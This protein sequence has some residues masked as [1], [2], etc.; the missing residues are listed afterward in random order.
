MPR[1]RPLIR[2]EQT[3]AALA[4]VLLL[5]VGAGAVAVT[6]A[7]ES[8]PTA[9]A[10]TIEPLRIERD[11]SHARFPY[12]GAVLLRAADDER[13]LAAAAEADRAAADRAAAERRRAAAAESRRADR[14]SRVR[15]PGGAGGTLGCI[16]SYEGDYGTE[17]GNGYSGAYQFDQ[18][19]WDGA[20]RRA[21]FAEWIGRRPSSA[22]PAVQDAVAAQLLAERGLQ[23]WGKRARANCG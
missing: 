3:H 14:S 8:R 15:N 13:F 9:A 5:F 17:T 19:T 21:G 16:R 12:A 2:H 18:S 7:G 1:P 20:A 22:P 11:D 4:V 23:P 6:N 10:E